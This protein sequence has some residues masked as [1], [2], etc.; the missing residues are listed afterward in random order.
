[1]AK[2]GSSST[3]LQKGLGLVLLGAGLIVLFVAG[4]FVYMGASATPLHRD[5]QKVPSVAHLAPPA[6]WAD[7]VERARQIARA[8]AAE[9][10]LPGLSVAVGA[11]GEMV[12]AEGFGWAHL[13]DR[14][15]VTADMRFRIGTASKVLTSAAVGLLIDEG[16][17]ALDEEIQKYVPAFPRKEWPVTLRQVLGH[18]AGIR[19]DEGDEE[20]LSVREDDPQSLRCP[21]TTEGLARF[22]ERPL[23]FEPGTEYRYSNY[24]WILVSAAVEAAAQEPFPSFMRRRVFE[25]LGMHDTTAEP[26]VEPSPERAT[27]YF[28]RFSADPRYGPDEGREVD[29][30]CF[31]GSAAFVSTPSDLARFGLALTDGKLLRPAT[32]QQLQASQRLSSGA[33]TG[34][35]LGWDLETAELSGTPVRSLGHDGDMM[36]GMV[37]SFLVF[38]DSGIVVAVT[39][40]IGYADTRA[41]TVKVAEAFAQK[42]KTSASR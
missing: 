19:R 6:K 14:V 5:P 35:G 32:L 20:P 2:E 11:G 22:A 33:E 30:S 27:F 34:Y 37:A 24:G 3:W 4:L 17:L 42:G 26:A 1:M 41:I 21:T 38:P 25:P 39:A 23:L 13:P 12:W 40:N 9:Q 31:S 8:G 29:Y 16:R 36:G 10:N 18:V 28:P 15:P 7:A